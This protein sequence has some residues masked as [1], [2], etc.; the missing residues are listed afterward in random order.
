M[1]KR[2]VIITL[3]AILLPSFALNSAEA[4]TVIATGTNP[5]LCNQIVSSTTGITAQ[6]SSQECI[7]TFANTT[8]ATWTV[9]SGVTQISAIIVG[10]G[11]GGGDSKADATGGGGGAGGFFQ[12][13][14]ISVSGSL[15]IA[16]GAGGAGSSQ[17]T[18]GGNGGN[19]YIGTLKVG[20][21]GG[22]NGV[23]YQGGARAKAGV[24]GTDFVSSGNGGGGR[25]TGVVSYTSEHLGGLAG[26]FAISGISFLGN[27]Y[28]GLQGSAGNANSDG[29]SGGMGGAISP[30]SNRTTSISG[31]S[32][33]YSKISGYRAWEDGASTAGTK[34]PGSGGSPNYSYGTDPYGSGGSGANG[35]VIIR[36]TI[37]AA[38]TNPTYTGVIHKSATESMTVTTTVPG[39]VRF[40][41]GS[42]RIPGCLA[43]STTGTAPELTATCTWKPAV[44][45]LQNVY[46]VITPT[47]VALSPTTSGRTS[48]VITNRQSNR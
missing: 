16:V 32:V 48:L 23:S 11:G 27:T 22:G 41:I 37:V 1:L 13:T 19:S 39:K 31:S 44:Q 30:S 25:P 15:A 9:P 46:A 36:Y 47:E 10:G 5:S 18:Q 34:T 3:V 2:P 40:F 33:V 6:R 29:A 26:D 43:V 42:K 45:G 24:G 28:T 38:I 12:N 21:G 17:T 4:A 7:V 35:V 8:E 20:G 14:N